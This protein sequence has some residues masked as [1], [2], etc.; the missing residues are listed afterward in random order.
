MS[1]ERTNSLPD[2]PLQQALEEMNRHRHHMQVGMPEVKV[3]VTNP[4]GTPFAPAVPL[5]GT[6]G[7]V[8]L[9]EESEQAIRAMIRE[10]FA[11]MQARLIDEVKQALANDWR[12]QGYTRSE[13]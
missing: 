6:T 9:T 13:R 2:D 8:M 3:R 5:L 10:E 12:M 7:R 11:A 1:E 4:D